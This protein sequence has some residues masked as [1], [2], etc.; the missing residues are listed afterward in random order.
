MANEVTVP[1]LPCASIDEIVEFY[2]LLGFRRTFGGRPGRQL[3]PPTALSWP[4]ELA[5]RPAP[6]PP[7]PNYG[8]SR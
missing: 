3:D 7:W 6:R 2:E 4:A 1:L 8:Q 5:S